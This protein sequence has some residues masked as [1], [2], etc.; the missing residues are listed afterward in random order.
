M[1]TSKPLF[2]VLM[3]AA[4]VAAVGT[5]S[6]HAQSLDI[7]DWVKNNALWWAEGSITDQDFV[8]A[9]QFLISRGIITI[10]SDATEVA[11]KEPSVDLPYDIGISFKEARY[12]SGGTAKIQIET[13]TPDQEK[14]RLGVFDSAGDIIYETT[15]KPNDF[16]T[17]AVEFRLPEYYQKD[18][19]LEVVAFFARDTKDKYTAS[20]F[21]EGMR[22]TGVEL[23]IDTGKIVSNAPVTV[24]VSLSDAVSK[25]IGIRVLDSDKNVLYDDAI[26]TNDFGTGKAEFA[27]PNYYLEDEPLEIVAFFAD[28]PSAEQKIVATVGL[29]KV[30]LTLTANKIAYAKGDP[31][32]ITITTNPP[33]STDIRLDGRDSYC[34]KDYSNKRILPVTIQTDVNGKASI[35]GRISENTCFSIYGWGYYDNFY[36]RI[37]DERFTP[38]N[39]LFI[40]SK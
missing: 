33:V 11:E 22:I 34:L 8:G 16:G 38:T 15:V 23:D 21:V 25:E 24:K 14:I 20:T 27:A 40:A 18:E 31:V 29:T 37:A 26:A 13:D 2:V 6:I 32:T 3:L 28:D 12:D 1:H 17:A 10:P 9:L 19:S 39:E 7:P 30:D 5:G 4:T 35:A 36:V